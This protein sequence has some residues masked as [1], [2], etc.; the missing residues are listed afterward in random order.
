MINPRIDLITILTDD[1]PAMLRFYRDVIGFHV[2]TDLG[3]Y[4]ELESEGV[5]FS[6]CTRATMEEATGYA[7]FK[8]K[9]A[10]QSFELAFPVDSPEAVDTTY[11]EIV[12][13]G[14]V[15]IHSPA[16]MPWGQRTAFFAD[17]DGN[18]HELFAE[19]TG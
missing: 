4:V 8:E 10:G 1:V 13:L 3:G 7:D 9:V 5:R 2:K 14:A 15:P 19:L 17:P 6:I 12:A 16:D 11:A 18:V